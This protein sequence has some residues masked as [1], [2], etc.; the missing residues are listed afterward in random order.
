MKVIAAIVCD[1]ERTAIGTRS[2][3]NDRIA[4]KRVI[5]HVVERLSQ[6]VGVDE[7]VLLIPSDQLDQAQGLSVRTMPLIPRPAGLD[8]RIR[9]SRQW[10]LTSWRGGA[11]QTTCFDEEYHPA[12]LAQAVRETAADHVL[13][14]HSHSILLDVAITSALINHHLHKNHEMRLTYTPCAPGL[15]GMVLQSGIVEEMGEKNVIPGQLLGY[16]PAAPTFDTLIRDACMQVDPALSKI[17]NRFCIDTDR[18]GAH[19]LACP[20]PS[21]AAF[22]LATPRC[23]APGVTDLSHAHPFPR[24][25]EIELTARRLTTPPGSAPPPPPSVDLRSTAKLDWAAWLADQRFPDDLLLTFAGHGDPLLYPHLLEVLRA[26]RK[27]NP[28]SIC[29][30]TDLVSDDIQ[31]LLTAINENLFDVLSITTYGHT[32]ATYAKVAQGGGTD[33]HA[34][35]VKNLTQLAPIISGRGGVPLVVPRILKV[36]ETI[37]EL[38]AFFDAWIGQAGW[39]VI[40]YP[41]D[42][43]GAVSF[44]GVIDMSPPKRKPCRRIWERLLILS[45]G[46]AVPCDQDIEAKLSLGNI[47]SHNLADLWQTLH[48]LRIRHA[49]GQWQ[50]IDPCKNCRE[51]H[52]A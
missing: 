20:P 49:A 6:V 48:G 3:L 46:V 30:Q 36:R 1:F 17:P 4:D 15:S 45:N 41:T 22:A 21:S 28:L 23:V 31:P 50:T 12:A 11:G 19:A 40:D 39:A 42:L 44:A 2:R 35:L 33:L 52:R 43:A 27:A 25:L 18:S 7:I 32:A 38:E 47:E 26:A 8:A 16:D 14:V 51:W 37:P 13:I 9:I 24:E 5:E 29:I 10:N 34:Q